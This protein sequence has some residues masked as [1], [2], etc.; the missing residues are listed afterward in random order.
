MGVGK[1]IMIMGM[2]LVMCHKILLE[3][4]YL[5]SQFGGELC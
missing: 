4:H 3:E 1:K 5:V 2:V